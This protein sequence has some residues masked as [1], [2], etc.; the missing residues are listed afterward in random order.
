MANLTT[1]LSNGVS[2]L[3]RA[4][5][6]QAQLECQTIGEMDSNPGDPLLLCHAGC[7]T[8]HTGSAMCKFTMSTSGPHANGGP[9]PATVVP[10]S[11]LGT[12]LANSTESVSQ[13]AYD[14]Q[15]V[16]Q[17]PSVTVMPGHALH[18]C[19][20]S[21]NNVPSWGNCKGRG[22]NPPRSVQNKVLDPS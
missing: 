12:D 7:L 9:H 14:K 3:L 10:N 22:R 11:T 15:L 2:G 17:A 1:S 19:N 8:R 21:Y 18:S 5:P 6:L 20:T 13:G 4:V 16:V